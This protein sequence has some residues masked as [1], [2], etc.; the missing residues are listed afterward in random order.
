M[1]SAADLLFFMFN[2]NFGKKKPDIK[3]YAIVGIVISSIIAVLSQCAGVSE[4]RLWD[5][6]DE[7]QRKYFPQG[8][9]NEFVLKDP[10]KLERRI[11][12]DV[13]KAI[14]DVTPEYDRIIREADQKYQPKYSEKLVNESVCYTD[15]CK[16]LGG[17][18]RICA[19]W[20]ENC[21][22]GIY[23]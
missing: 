1:G 16:A 5:L 13:D 18:M 20:I 4:N 12:R 7:I 9:L 14:R 3:Q 11:K 8:I 17:E 15:E 10:E 21:V 22:F 19:L 2:F 6:L 23:K